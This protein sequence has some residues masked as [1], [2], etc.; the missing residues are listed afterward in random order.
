MK[1]RQK[2][3]DFF[4]ANI[5][6]IRVDI[7]EKVIIKK[8]NDNEYVY[9]TIRAFRNSKGK[10]DNERKSIGKIDKKSGKLIPNENYFK[11]VKNVIEP[12][13]IEVNNTTIS[14]IK[15]FGA[16]Y[17]LEK[18]F[19]EL[20]L[21]SYLENSFGQKVT[22]KIKTTSMYMCIEGMAMMY[23]NDFCNNHH[24]NSSLNLTSPRLSELFSSINH[25]K[26]MNFFKKWAKYI[27][28]Q[29]Y[30][31]YD[32]TSISSY[33]KGQVD[34]ERGYNRDKEKLPQINLGM[35]FGEKSCL[36]VFY[37]KYS[38][39]IVD[40]SHLIY[41][42]E[43]NK[44]LAIKNVSFVM[45]KGFYSRNNLQYMVCNNYPLVMCVSDKLITSK[46]LLSKYKD[47][48]TMYDNYNKDLDVYCIKDQTVT[49]GCKVDTY[50]YYNPQ[51]AILE[52]KDLYSKVEKYTSELNQLKTLTKKQVK[53]YSKFFNIQVND[54][55]TFTFEV[56]GEKIDSIKELL[57]FFV[58]ISTV[59]NI[60]KFELLEIYRR[61]DKV[62]KAFC[63]LK[64]YLDFK[65]LNTHNV[66]TTEGKI[67]IGFISLILKSYMENKLK[68]YLHEKNTSIKMILKDLSNIR[69][70]KLNGRDILHTPLTSRQKKILSYFGINE[71]EIK[72]YLKLL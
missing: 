24:L 30:I 44:E 13:K 67:F 11:Y 72:N 64:N 48:I 8:Q 40:K 49:Y 22:D 31:A 14:S 18:I 23:I 5:S 4:L 9:Y 70:V 71:E 33:S 2:K 46:N 25:D 38:G 59:K 63:N 51:K 41:M 52:H 42:M 45:D 28:E 57:G 10:P 1:I 26:R 21:N 20:G 65:R 55:D 15:S 66:K 32:V 47:K 43:Y 50:I 39:S 62:E 54:D 37:T 56:N 6:D 36:P 16:T 7:P 35:Y 27:S 58:L 34:V 17:L 69:I 29:E 19:E 3:S 53:F 12:E 68:R 60:D 61:K